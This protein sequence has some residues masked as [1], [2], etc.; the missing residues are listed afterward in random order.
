MIPKIDSV[1]FEDNY[2]LIVSF[3]GAVV[4][5]VDAQTFINDERL[6]AYFNEIRDNIEL[7]K[8][9]LDGYGRHFSQRIV[10][11]GQGTR[12]ENGPIRKNCLP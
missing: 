9:Y 7:F 5:E 1:I 3:K 6:K 11:V 4:K 8:N 2:H 12:W 10:D